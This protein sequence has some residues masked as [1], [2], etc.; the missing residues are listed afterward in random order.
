M[1]I[2]T[3]PKSSAQCGSL[4]THSSALYSFSPTPSGSAVESFRLAV[5]HRFDLQDYI[6]IYGPAVPSEE[7]PSKLQE[8][9]KFR[10]RSN[11]IA[12]VQWSLGLHLVT[13]DSPLS[14]RCCVYT[15]AGECLLNL[16]AY[17][18]ALGIRCVAPP[19]SGGGLL[20]VGSFDGSARLLSVFSWQL[21]FELAHSVAGATGCVEGGDRS[22][23]CWVE[24]EATFARRRLKV[25]PRLS[26]A[27][28]AGSGALPAM[29]VGWLAWSSDGLLLA[30]KEEAHPR[31][32]WVWRPL[33]ARLEALLV[34]AE[35][36]QCARW[37]PAGSVA[38][39][40]FC[41]SS[42]R[43]GLWREGNEGVG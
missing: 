37:R 19:G 5:V 11:D 17:Q 16:E 43:V 42:G 13:A 38:V 2:I 28:S 10:A 7:Q 27:A 24:S 4:G 15:P 8:L 31:C 22:V 3:N 1:Y 26:P 40:A 9:V 6:A 36:L 39:L 23:Q 14:Y 41:S 30:A 20:A 32:L 21:A 12:S 35:P 29:G 18:H 34:L 25:L 33:Q